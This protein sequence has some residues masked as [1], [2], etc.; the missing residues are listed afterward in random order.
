[1]HNLHARKV[2]AQGLEDVALFKEYGDEDKTK[3]YGGRESVIG[4]II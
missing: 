1:M 2:A 3:G 4:D